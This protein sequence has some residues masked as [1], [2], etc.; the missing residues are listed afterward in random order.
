MLILAIA[1]TVIYLTVFT[2]PSSNK[3][4]E[5]YILGKGDKADR[6]PEE[7]SAGEEGTITAVI[8]N[9]EHQ[10]VSYRI[11]VKMDGIILNEI[12][13]VL[14]DNDQKWEEEISFIPGTAGMNKKLEI[15]LFKDGESEPGNEL[16][17]WL[18]VTEDS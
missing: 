18:D 14:L 5:F 10:T 6:Y 17:L 9:K 7:L 4:T 2:V 13:P 8:V 11:E 1:G 15:L 12:G 3:F 16:Y